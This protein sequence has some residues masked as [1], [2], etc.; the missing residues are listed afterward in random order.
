MEDILCDISAFRLYRTPPAVLG[1]FDG[2][3]IARDQATRQSLMRLPL[4]QH[5]LGVPLHFLVDVSASRSCAKN[6]KHHLWTGNMPRGAI[7]ESAGAGDL[8]SPEMTLLLMARWMPVVRLALCMYE[9]CGTFAVYSMP[10]ELQELVT[11]NG[12]DRLNIQAGWRRVHNSK[13]AATDLW[14]RP[15][16]LRLERLKEFAELNHSA[17]GGNAFYK[18]TSMVA[19]ITRSPLEAQAALLLS[20]PRTQG[21]YGFKLTTN[22]PIPLSP[23][24]RKIYPHEYC[25]AD[26]YIESPNG[27]HIVAVECQGEAIHSGEA[28]L[29]S[30]ANRTTALETMGINVVQITHADIRSAE[31]MEL[32]AEHIAHKLKIYPRARTVRM[33]AAERKIRAEFPHNWA[34]LSK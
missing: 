3:P 21:G 22:H 2:L 5:V 31:R 10:Q 7:Y 14:V 30:D 32:I 6:I 25:E 20:L 28:A 13:G 18:A 15:A 23:S 9:L 12:T 27:E 16:P 17:Y 24:A 34:D 8:T 1:L 11:K 26:I 4:V 33:V 19:G 29:A